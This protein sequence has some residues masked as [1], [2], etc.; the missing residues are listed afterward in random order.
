M[1]SE[2]LRIDRIKLFFNE[3]YVNGKYSGIE[4]NELPITFALIYQILYLFICYYLSDTDF[5]RLFANICTTFINVSIIRGLSKQIR[6]LITGNIT[7]KST[8]DWY[9]P[10]E[11]F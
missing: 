8:N 1:G 6:E 11:Y 9:H 5:V 2:L 3:F 4:T 10:N 7:K